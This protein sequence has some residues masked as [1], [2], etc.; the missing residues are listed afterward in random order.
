MLILFFYFFKTWCHDF[1]VR[2]EIQQPIFRN[3]SKF[4]PGK[5]EGTKI[6]HGN[7]NANL[8]PKYNMATQIKHGNTNT[9]WVKRAQTELTQKMYEA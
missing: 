8:Q 2:I 3:I 6:Q 9:I 1:F 7:T 4:P 5:A